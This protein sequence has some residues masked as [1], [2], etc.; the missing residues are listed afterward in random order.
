[1]LSLSKVIEEKP[2]NSRGYTFFRYK[3]IV[4]QQLLQLSTCLNS[5][6]IH[7]LNSEKRDITRP[8]DVLSFTEWRTVFVKLMMTKILKSST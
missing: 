6:A 5:E 3:H 8:L 1:M 4:L 2:F 7:D